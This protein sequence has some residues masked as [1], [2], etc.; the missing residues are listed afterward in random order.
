MKLHGALSLHPQLFIN[1]IYGTARVAV[2]M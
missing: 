1:F 2:I